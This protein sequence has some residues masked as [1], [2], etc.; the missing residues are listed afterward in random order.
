M[1]TKMRESTQSKILQA[2]IDRRN[3]LWVQVKA[4]NPTYTL[5]QV[6][7]RLEQLGA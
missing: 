6:E 4:A 2:Y 5:G 3:R 7:A 1:I